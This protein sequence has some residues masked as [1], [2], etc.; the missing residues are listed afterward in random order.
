MSPL[1]ILVYIIVLVCGVGYE[2]TRDK[3]NGG[4]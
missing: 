4:E 2:I 1:I 3:S